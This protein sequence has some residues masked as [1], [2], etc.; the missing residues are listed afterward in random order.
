MRRFLF[1]SAFALLAVAVP[2]RAMPFHP[3]AKAPDIAL[4]AMGCGPGWVRGPY[5]G[6]HPMGNGYG[7]SYGYHPYYYH[8]YYRHY[9]HPYY[10]RYYDPY[11]YY[12]YYYHHYHP[13]YHNYYRPY[14][15]RYYH[16]PYYHRYYTDLTIIVIIT[17][18]DGYFV[19]IDNN[20]CPSR[21]R[22]APAGQPEGL[23]GSAQ[24]PRRVDVSILALARSTT[25]ARGLDLLVQRRRDKTAAVKLMRKLLKKHGFAP[26][27]LV[28]Q[29]AFTCRNEVRTEIDGSA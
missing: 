21:A 26:D 12:N 20:L 15:H 8:T 17:A 3:I 28:T 22:R 10:R 1:A 25:K 19:T 5:G 7:Y 23:R 6:C 14:Y 13:Y 29:A 18:T 2:A 16:H 11:Y 24:A 9:Y 4:V 27:V